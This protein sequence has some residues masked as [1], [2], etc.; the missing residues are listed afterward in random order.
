MNKSWQLL[1][2]QNK[3]DTDVNKVPG[4]SESGPHDLEKGSKVKL[5]FCADDD[6]SDIPHTEYLWVEILL[7]QDDKYL[8]Q[9]QD[10]PKQINN[11]SMGELIEFDE[12]HIYESEYIDPFGPSIKV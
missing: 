10:Q 11:L 12:Q 4:S 5:I 2:S 3:N 6:N 8:G 7:V 9:L 1:Y